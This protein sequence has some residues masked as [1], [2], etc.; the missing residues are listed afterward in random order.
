M[1]FNANKFVR[2]EFLRRRHSLLPKNS[3]PFSAKCPVHANTVGANRKHEPVKRERKLTDA[4]MARW[5]AHFENRA[6]EREFLIQAVGLGEVWNK[7]RDEIE[8]TVAA[9]LEQASNQKLANMTQASFDDLRQE[10]KKIRGGLTGEIS[11]AC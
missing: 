3:L 9:K 5:N 7:L 6:N 4:E 10:I 8:K 1:Y 2:L 11:P